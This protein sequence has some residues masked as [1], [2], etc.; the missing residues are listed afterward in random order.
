VQR[1]REGLT[2]PRWSTIDQK[3]FRNNYGVPSFYR[4]LQPSKRKVSRDAVK[5]LILSV[6]LLAIAIFGGELIVV[7]ARSLAAGR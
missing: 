2:A 4:P 6:I 3:E 1:N 5:V 7:L